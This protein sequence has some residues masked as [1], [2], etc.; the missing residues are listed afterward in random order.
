MNNLKIIF[1]LIF[2]LSL[3][4]CRQK[5]QI[6]AVDDVALAAPEAGLVE[7]WEGETVEEPVEEEE[8]GP[9]TMQNDIY[10]ENG[11]LCGYDICEYDEQ[12][13]VTLEEQ[14]D[15]DGNCTAR[16][17]RSYSEDGCKCT[18]IFYS[19]GELMS[20]M[21]TFFDER[22]M[23]TEFRLYDN[24]DALMSVDYYDENGT[25]SLT[26]IFMGEA[27]A[28]WKCGEL[29]YG[30]N[31]SVEERNFAPDGRQTMLW[32]REYDERHRSVRD[33]FY[34]EGAFRWDRRSTY[35]ERD[36]CIRMDDYDENGALLYYTLMDYTP[37][38]YCFLEEEYN[39]AGELL[40][41]ECIEYRE[42]GQRLSYYHYNGQAEL[43]DYTL[44]EYDELGRVT[45]VEDFDAED[46]PAGSWKYKYAED[47][48]YR[49]TSFYADG[50]LAGV[51]NYDAYGNRID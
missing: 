50:R 43:H 13:R 7:A 28:E 36:L 15:L 45:L 40:D 21:V 18:T 6:P 12:D 44:Y 48:S 4:G 38:G 10:D 41:R 42:D 24:F 11:V 23:E 9:R 47:G 1:I 2:A 25:V 3:V 27:G 20:K 22:G 14:F 19:Y 32:Q 51:E 30:E 39:P 37:E 34:E 26:E 33:V 8:S 5:G 16:W 29:T 46:N 17:E 49:V 35:D 31:G